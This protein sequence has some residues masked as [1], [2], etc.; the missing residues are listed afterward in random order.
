MN[1]LVQ[2]KLT[3]GVVVVGLAPPL[4]GTENLL[5]A[6]IL[7]L[8]YRL[9]KG[10]SVT[11]QMDGCSSLSTN[12]PQVTVEQTPSPCLNLGISVPNIRKL[13]QKGNPLFVL[14]LK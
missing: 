11:P 14:L 12:L 10:A 9:S 5:L 1:G 6:Q 13:P 3:R 7:V 2:W 8:S 4:T